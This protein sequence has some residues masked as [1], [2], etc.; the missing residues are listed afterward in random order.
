MSPH[1]PE[2]PYGDPRTA[3]STPRLGPYQ[4][5]YDVRRGYDEEPSRPDRATLHR[6]FHDPGWIGR[7]RDDR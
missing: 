6:A 4:T 2:D 7:R 1:T 3:S 5:E